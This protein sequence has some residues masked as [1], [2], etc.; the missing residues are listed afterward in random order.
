[1][2]FLTEFLRWSKIQDYLIDKY[3][4]LCYDCGIR[5]WIE[6][7]WENANGE[8]L[9]DPIIVENLVLLCPQCYG[10]RHL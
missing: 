7:Q 8:P 2:D 6:S 4:G 1:M 3:S 9:G 5:S 10:N